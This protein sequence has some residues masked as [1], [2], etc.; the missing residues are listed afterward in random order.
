MD[1]TATQVNYRTEEQ[2]TN[3]EAVIFATRVWAEQPEDIEQFA[4]IGRRRTD[5]RKT[6]V[7]RP[8]WAFQ[9]IS[10]FAPFMWQEARGLKFAAVG[11]Y[12]AEVTADKLDG[13]SVPEDLDQDAQAISLRDVVAGHP[14]KDITG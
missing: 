12:F 14:H 11:V 6:G 8:G 4:A 7:K 10:V 1:Q 5:H 2:R 9:R 3:S 13:W